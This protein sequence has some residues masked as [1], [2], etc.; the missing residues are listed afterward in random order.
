[1]Y[2]RQRRESPVKQEEVHKPIIATDHRHQKKL[3]AIQP[4]PDRKKAA[5]RDIEAIPKLDLLVPSGGRGGG[6]GSGGSGV[7]GRGE[8]PGTA[9]PP[10]QPPQ[11]SI[12][13][14]GDDEREE[15]VVEQ[16]EGEGEA[17]DGGGGG[18]QVG[19]GPGERGEEEEEEL[20]VGERRVWPVVCVPGLFLQ[21]APGQSLFDSTPQERKKEERRRT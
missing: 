7:G 12:E 13:E 3:H 6:R 17:E 19:E 4:N 5:T 21:C 9:G 11:S 1:V 15:E 8:P 18:G 10:A 14:R 16:D 2:N 20:Q